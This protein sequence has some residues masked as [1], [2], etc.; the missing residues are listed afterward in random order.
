[1]NAMTPLPSRLLS[2]LVPLLLLAPSCGSRHLQALARQGTRP[3]QVHV[4]WTADPQH[5]ATVE[6]TTAEQG[7]RHELMLAE[8]LPDPVPEAP[9]VDVARRTLEAEPARAF[10]GGGHGDPKLWFHR[11]RL[12]GLAPATTYRF[13]VRSDGDTSREF[14]FMTAP[15]DDRPVTILAGSD[16]RS[17]R[18]Q[19]RTMDRRIAAIVAADP[20]ILAL[21]FGGDY[22]WDGS[23]LDLFAEWL[24][25]YELTTTADGRILPIIP[26]RGNHEGGGALFD[27]IFDSPGGGLGHNYYAL[28]LSAAVLWITLD[29]QIA[30]GGEQAEFLEKALKGASG[31]TWKVAQYHQPLWPAVKKD[32]AAKPNWL[33]LFERYGLNLGVESDGHVLKRTVPIK[34]GKEAPDGVV[35]IGEGGLGVKQRSPHTGRWYLQSPG[36]TESRYHVWRL[37]F[38]RNRAELTAIGEDGEVADRYELLPH[39]R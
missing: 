1:M 39:R 6:W 22:V 20:S 9:E 33:P 35:Y 2:V 16:S 7:S 12:D 13:V 3:V 21:A 34:N 30:T 15:A 5:T 37:H 17:D 25:D 14:H 26:T 19:R 11:V 27:Q 23:R 8:G 38:E 24:S 4:V 36:N 28:K 18:E 32:A 10:A 29:S 31:V